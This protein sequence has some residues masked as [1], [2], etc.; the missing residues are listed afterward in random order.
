[1]SPSLLVNAAA[2][3][4]GGGLTYL[5]NQMPALAHE[6][7]AW[8]IVY[9][10]NPRC[11][12]AVLEASRG[13][14]NIT[15]SAPAWCRAPASLRFVL[16]QVC[17]PVVAKGIT[18]DVVLSLGGFGVTRLRAPQVVVHHNPNHYA[19]RQQLGLSAVLLR[20]RLES[21]VSKQTLRRV[22]AKISP[23]VAHAAALTGARFSSGWT[24]VESGV[25]ADIL[26]GESGDLPAGVRDGFALAVHNWYR[27][28]ELP[29]L[30][31]TWPTFP[32]AKDIQLV[33]VGHPMATRLAARIRKAAGRSETVILLSEATRSEVLN[34]Y[35]RCVFYVSTAS[36][37][38]FPLT[39]FEAM[40]SMAP[41]VL[42]DIPA[43]A[44]V[45][46]DAAAYFTPGDRLSMKAAI[47][48]VLAD[49]DIYVSR[50]A[51][52]LSVYGWPNHARRLAEVLT[53]LV[54]ESDRTP[55]G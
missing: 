28:K 21:W 10:V 33:I 49:P 46:G 14:S 38:A 37:E 9:V 36:L 45:A 16:E 31:E 17:I 40:A 39:P 30:V 25:S 1:M 19:T 6:L 20:S 54:S 29:W 26:R 48:R 8:H 27:H 5:I 42:S 50:G 51:E 44:E 7:A 23:T 52:R 53:R 43:H 4:P 2:I 11:L 15:I 55:G 13:N 47:D 18:A 24:V 41:C 3:A 34:L 22:D 35:S 32:I 12:E